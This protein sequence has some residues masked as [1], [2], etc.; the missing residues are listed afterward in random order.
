MI[1]NEIDRSDWL[2]ITEDCEYATFFHSPIWSD[3]VTNA[4][5]GIHDKSLLIKFDNGTDA[6]LPLVA[7]SVDVSSFGLSINVSQAKSTWAG[8]FGDII[9]DGDLPSGWRRCYQKGLES[10]SKTYSVNIVGNPLFGQDQG[11]G[12]ELDG[13]D[14]EDDF[15]QLIR[16]KEYDDFDTLFS[17]FQSDVRQNTRQARKNGLEVRLADGI[18]DWKNYFGA[19]QD[20]LERWGDSAT[21]NYDWEIFESLHNI[22]E[23]HGEHVKLWL[24]EKDGELAS[25]D[26][27]FYWNEH[28]VCWHAASYRE[29]LEYSPNDLLH[30]EKIQDA[31]DRELSYYD[32]NPSGGHK[33]VVNFKSKFAT[34]KV[35]IKRWTW[36]NSTMEKAKSLKNLFSSKYSH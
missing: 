18:D 14:V 8:C 2:R 26:I 32:F 19:Y 33:G 27:N 24:V 13:M 20:S 12:E 9:A 3:A 7:K 5:D 16:L 31:M 21:N 17:D 15:T 6:V 35:P 36:I 23:I 29:Y 34:E 11:L 22:A 4:F 25:G 28:T 1:V 30:A 10:L